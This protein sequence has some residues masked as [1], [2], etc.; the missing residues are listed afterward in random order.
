MRSIPD[1]FPHHRPCIVMT[2]GMNET[3]LGMQ[4]LLVG[5]AAFLAS[6][7]PQLES[8]Q[9]QYTVNI[10]VLSVPVDA[11]AIEWYSTFDRLSIESS[12][13]IVDC[14]VYSVSHVPCIFNKTIFMVFSASV[15]EIKVL[16]LMHR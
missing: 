8:A 11:C 13:S 10:N 5:A 9:V 1:F 16:L 14:V 7:N 15:F 3:C 6:Y 2:F 12:Y 4:N